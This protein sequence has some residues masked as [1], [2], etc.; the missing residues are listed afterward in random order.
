MVGNTNTLKVKFTN[1]CCGNI[2]STN[3]LL[4]LLAL[5]EAAPLLLKGTQNNPQGEQIPVEAP[6]E[7]N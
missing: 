6:K 4:L 1:F 3:D 2:E 5:A 7:L